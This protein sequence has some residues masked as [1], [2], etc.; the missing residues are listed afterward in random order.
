VYAKQAGNPTKSAFTF[1]F[2]CG[3]RTTVLGM[4]SDNRHTYAENMYGIFSCAMKV[5]NIGMMEMCT[6]T[7]ERMQLRPILRYYPGHTTGAPN[8]MM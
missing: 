8:E 4:W 1:P 6:A 5:H 7:F 2:G 3:K